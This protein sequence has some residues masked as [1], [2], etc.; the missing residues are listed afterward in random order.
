MAARRPVA[1]SAAQVAQLRAELE[2]ND[3][4]RGYVLKGDETW[5]VDQ[6][7]DAISAAA[8]RAGLEYCRHD[9][10]DPDFDLSKLLDDLGA[11]PMFATGRCVVARNPVDSL[12]KVATKDS[13]FTRAALAELAD[14]SR[15]G[16]LV[17]AGAGIRADHAVAKA[18]VKAGG[19]AVDC[20]KLKDL[21]REYHNPQRGQLVRWIESR[22]RELGVKL[23]NDD[24]YYLA[25][26]TGNDLA[27][28][29][30]ELKGLQVSGSADIREK[31]AWEH[32]GTP[33]QAADDLL[34]GQPARGLAAIEALF[35][36][37]FTQ[38]D[39]RSEKSAGALAPMILGTLRTKARQG[40]TIA[41]GMANGMSLG[42]AAEQVGVSGRW[43]LEQI[44]P[45]LHGRS[46]RD[47]ARIL[48]DVGELERAIR[49]A[50]GVDVNDFA[51]LALRWRRAPENR[52]ARGGAGARRR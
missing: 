34:S 32:G 7:L 41:Q 6:A 36:G 17:I 2:S 28:L 31:I 23:S 22:A 16:C 40:F 1:D 20:S 3:L 8:E 29:D 18:I 24:A 5:F 38:K 39:G 37:G 45:L 52:Q 10:Q 44:E 14:A 48:E 15:K 19:K 25:C 33:W 46:A 35:R 43:Q 12:K 13:P 9:E 49:G 50:A 27:A 4:K 26:A 11:L 21:A 51:R 47:W 42:A 30:S